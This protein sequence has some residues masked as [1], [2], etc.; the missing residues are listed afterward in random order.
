[1]KSKY[2]LKRVSLIYLIIT[3][4]SSLFIGCF[5]NNSDN[6]KS[7]KLSGTITV[8]SWNEE[9]ITSGIIEEF[10]KQYPE[11]N[12]ELVN[13]PN[14][15]NAYADRLVATLKSGV[16]A[17]DVFL[18]EAGLVERIKDM[19]VCEN[20]SEDPYNAGNL[21]K[22][23][24]P[25]TVE[26]GKDEN[27]NLIALAWQATP[28][29]YYYRRSLANKYLGTDDPEKI[30]AMMSNMDDFIKLGET[31]RDKSNGEVYLLG[32][33]HELMR[34][35]LANR[36]D[37][38]VKDN[39]IIIDPAMEEAFDLTAKITTE[40]VCNNTWQWSVDWAET[41]SNGRVF[42]FVLPTWGISSTIPGNAPDT[43]GDWGLV[44]APIPYFWGGTW[45]SIYKG[46][47]KKELSWEFIKFL[48]SNEEFL[49]NYAKK[50][51]DFVN[52]KAIQEKIADSDDQKNEFL[53]GQN[54][55]KTYIQM[56]DKI[57]FINSTEY[58]DVLNDL[59][60][61]CLSEY[62]EGK[63]TRDMVDDTFRNKVKQKYPYLE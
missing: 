27:G 53:G 37:P 6:K 17:P 2:I 22:N 29:G 3:M 58:D 21:I 32:S 31:I 44:K 26:T 45:T 38:W 23:M 49:E 5:Q 46:S 56:V 11:I 30:Q 54:P 43:K 19:D 39:K 10:Q 25:Y 28:G 55:Y 8:W 16:N 33:I 51:G 7:E 61:Q 18:A 9:L 40:N 36:K 20:L 41:M 48:T 14:S 24:V 47:N 34:I 59:W 15:G 60:V 35:A 57:N 13:V 50:T 63:I 42:G 4:M 52:N 62:I 12:V 1:M